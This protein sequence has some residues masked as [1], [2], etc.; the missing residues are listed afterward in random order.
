RKLGPFLWQLPPSF[1]YEHERIED[2]FRRL[3]RSFA[4]AAKLA[5]TADFIKADLPDPLPRRRLRHALEVRH[6]SFETPDFVE[7]A[8]RH[9]VAIVFA[10]TAGKWPYLED[11]TSDFVY[12]RLHGE[13]ELYKSGYD[14]GSLRW[15]AKRIKH[16]QA[17]RQ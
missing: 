15:W 1:K 12:A 10:D 11:L 4:Q 2:F 8:R 13:I 5:K 17:G 3:P 9:D 16:W 6:E 14:D 7:L